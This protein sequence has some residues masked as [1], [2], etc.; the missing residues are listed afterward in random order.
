MSFMFGFKAEHSLTVGM[1][2]QKVTFQPST[3]FKP[4][5]KHLLM[6][7]CHTHIYEPNHWNWQTLSIILKHEL[8]VLIHNILSSYTCISFFLSF[9]LSLFYIFVGEVTVLL[10]IFHL[11][12]IWQV[13][14]SQ[15]PCICLIK[16]V[17]CLLV[18]PALK[19][20]HNNIH[21]IVDKCLLLDV[22]S[23]MSI[24]I[25]SFCH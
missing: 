2:S 18:F 25:I 13:L 20:Q 19:L 3:S 1:D 6:N 12:W 21:F 24:L 16:G 5:L 9:F 22:M 23:Y 17:Q 8:N 10:S 4:H 14:W 7:P 15:N 11:Y